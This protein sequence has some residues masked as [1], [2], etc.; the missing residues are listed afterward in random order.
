[1]KLKAFDLCFRAVQRGYTLDEIRPCVVRP[2]GGGA[3]D[4]DVEHEAYP[5]TLRE[6]Y[7]PPPS[8]SQAATEMALSLVK[9]APPPGLGDMVAAGLEAVGI[10]KERVSAAIGRDCGCKGRQEA[11]NAIGRRIGIG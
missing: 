4:V 10:T 9:A 3:Y 6:G 11:L 8:I 1:M 7:T 2:L 5:R